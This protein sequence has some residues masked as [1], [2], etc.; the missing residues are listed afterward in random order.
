MIRPKGG[1]EATGRFGRCG[2]ARATTGHPY[3]DKHAKAYGYRLP[4]VSTHIV[5]T[6]IAELQAAGW[7]QRAIAEAA[8]VA[9]NTVWQ[10]TRRDVMRMQTARRIVALR[11]KT[12]NTHRVPAWPSARRLRSLQAAGWTGKQLAEGTGIPTSTISFIVNA[13]GDL[14]ARTQA[15]VIS[16][17]W[18]E[19][20]T[21]PVRTPTPT[22]KRNHW[23]V[24]MW[25][26]NIDNPREKP[27]VTHCADCHAPEVGVK[28]PLCARCRNSRNGHAYRQRKKKQKVKAA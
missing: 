18:R 25:W 17:F 22:A 5:R 16:R 24:P 27:G 20:C 9:E 10:A 8:G 28:S 19:H 26:D 11:G 13:K 1:C 2:L 7:S 14:I 21:D 12:P 3:C 4:K 23:P 6:V 15:E